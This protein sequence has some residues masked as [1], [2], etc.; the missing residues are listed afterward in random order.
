MAEHQ[1]ECKA[2]AASAAAMPEEGEVVKSFDQESRF[3]LRLV[4]GEEDRTRAEREGF[5]CIICH[6]LMENP[7]Q[8]QSCGH[9]LCKSCM[10][11]LVA[12]EVDFS[13]CCP[14]CRNL[15]DPD[16][17]VT[18]AVSVRL[19]ING[20]KV[21]CM[22]SECAWQGSLGRAEEHLQTECK[23]ALSVM[24]VCA[25]CQQKVAKGDLEDHTTNHCPLRTVACD[26][27]YATV[28][29][30]RKQ[31]HDAVCCMRNG[32]YGA[33]PNLCTEGGRI[34]SDKLQRHLL[35]CPYAS[36]ACRHPG[37]Y[38]T[39]YLKDIKVLEDW[40]KEHHRVLDEIRAQPVQSPGDISDSQEAKS[41]PSHHETPPSTTI[42][43]VSGEVCTARRLV[44]CHNMTASR[45]RISDHK[46][47]S[48]A[49]WTAE[50]LFGGYNRTEVDLCGA[51]RTAQ[52]GL[53]AGDKRCVYL[54]WW[55]LTNGSGITK[56]FARGEE[57]LRCVGSEF[58]QPFVNWIRTHGRER[59]LTSDAYKVL[60]DLHTANGTRMHDKP[61]IL[62]LIGST[63]SLVS[64]GA[65][66]DA[67]EAMLQELA[68]MQNAH[69]EYALYRHHTRVAA[70][71][72]L[73]RGGVPAN[74]M[75]EK[76]RFALLCRS[77]YSRLPHALYAR[78][79]EELDV[80]H[81]HVHR[82]R[83]V[84]MAFEYINMA[85]KYGC[86]DALLIIAASFQGD[87]IEPNPNGVKLS[88]ARV[89]SM[90]HFLGLRADLPRAMIC[91]RK[92]HLLGHPK[93]LST[94]ASIITNNA[95]SFCDHM[96][97]YLIFKRGIEGP[98][99]RGLRP[100]RSPA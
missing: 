21:R 17:E 25:S 16:C 49:Y 5:V 18:D 61:P 10:T 33:C 98:H 31:V 79:L 78:A 9:M 3:D 84:R 72:A 91:L 35:S 48:M 38:E 57:V 13:A 77:A 66:D 70:E 67:A 96:T 40:H 28:I 55:G 27:C 53:A 73:G 36:T 71:R 75:S 69:S 23:H 11:K 29:Y 74:L 14:T 88:H 12:R 89:S 43:P 90:Y 15:F 83:D 4:V 32:A 6:L 92:A 58:A 82:V 22:A 1:S 86:G 24:D 60:S 51:M 41:G 19:A 54:L 45:C 44:V 93:A 30:E 26:Q 65:V 7:Q 95:A 80:E 97:D 50:E 47:Y 39:V 81:K 64:N 34:P 46:D 87:T 2:E 42:D 99:A 62:D 100:R 52:Y 20:L 85:A 37:C 76:Q 63:L 94:L 8:I 59:M 68:A 56:S